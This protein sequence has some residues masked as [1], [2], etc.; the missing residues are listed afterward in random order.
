[1]AASV[2]TILSSVF[3]GDVNDGKV[4]GNS[5]GT[6]TVLRYLYVGQKIQEIDFGSL[7]CKSIAILSLREQELSC[8]FTYPQ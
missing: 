8:T 1:M 3:K 4:G 6:K 5:G 7:R 2:K